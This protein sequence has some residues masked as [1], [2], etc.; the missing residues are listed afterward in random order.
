LDWDEYLTVIRESGFMQDTEDEIYRLKKRVSQLEARNKSQEIILFLILAKI[1][2]YILAFTMDLTF[3]WVFEV[4]QWILLICIIGSIYSSDSPS[5]HA[6]ASFQE[7]RFQED[8]P[9][10]YDD[11]RD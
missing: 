8:H 1:S 9:M 10:D 3:F 11:L 5:S 7:T 6:T 2:G 4:I